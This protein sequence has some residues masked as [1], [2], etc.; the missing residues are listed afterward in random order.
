MLLVEDL[1]LL[2]LDDESGEMA[3]ITTLHYA[4]GGAVLVE[5]ALAHRVQ[6]DPPAGF[7]KTETVHVVPESE[8]EEPAPS[9]SVLADPILRDAYQLVAAKPR[10]LQDMLARIGANLHRTVTDRLVE[11]GLVHKTSKRFLGIFRTTAW[12]AE[13][14]QYEQALRAEI[15][16]ALT[17]R[18]APSPRVAALIALL[19]A[20]QQLRLLQ[21]PEGLTAQDV[22]DRATELSKGNWGAQTVS[23]AVTQAHAAIIAGTTAAVSG[24]VAAVMVSTTS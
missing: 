10:Y 17:S 12:P 2:L 1:M 23:D 4:L 3:A 22:R 6:I 16:R 14:V 7:W 11:R 21:I 15:S 24:A 19:M 20:S 8:G 18:E 9:D 5:L 13:D